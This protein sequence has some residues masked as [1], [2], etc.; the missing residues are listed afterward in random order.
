MIQIEPQHLKI[1]KDVLK[2]YPYSFYAFGSRVKGTAK[3]FSDLDICYKEDIPPFVISQLQE[4]FE[5]SDL[6]F[7]VEFVDWMQC[8][9]EFQANIQ[10]DLE[11]VLDEE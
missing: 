8:T 10:N 4:D 3:R 6:P 9:K 11:L 7:K 5:K 1:V 2:K